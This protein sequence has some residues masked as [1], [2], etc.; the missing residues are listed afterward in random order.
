[1]NEQE[2]QE[3][4]K[5]A[6]DAEPANKRLFKQLKQKSPKDLDQ[7]VQQLHNQAFEQI[8][9]TNCANCCKTTSPRFIPKDIE[10]LSKHFRISPGDF[11]RQY[12]KIDEDSDYVLQQTPCPFLG[13]DNLC[14]VYEHR[15]NAC[16]EYP[17]TNQRKF[18]RHFGITLN[19]TFICPA[20]YQIVAQLQQVYGK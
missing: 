10:R 15:P 9:C 16:R 11:T 14:L 2:R 4:Q 12:L 19:N 18:H 20:V 1:M 17:H 13:T 5:K 3:L 8:D 7:T 6:K